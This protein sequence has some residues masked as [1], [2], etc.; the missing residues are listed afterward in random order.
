MA[1]INLGDEVK[2]LVTGF[3]GIV[4]GKTTWLT[5]CD[6][7]IVQPKGVNKEGKIYDN[8]SFDEESLIVVKAKKVKEGQRETGGPSVYGEVKKY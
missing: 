7:F 6:R 1:K 4:I 8:S 5:G 2:D 3:T